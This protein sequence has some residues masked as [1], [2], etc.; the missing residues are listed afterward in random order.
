MPRDLSAS[1]NS[2]SPGSMPNMSRISLGITICPF[3]PTL[4]SDMYLSLGKLG[5]LIA[6]VIDNSYTCITCITLYHR[7]ALMSTVIFSVL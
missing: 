3:S 4:T 1:I 6:S 2:V 7:F 5:V